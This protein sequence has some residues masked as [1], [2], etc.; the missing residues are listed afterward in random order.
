MWKVVESW[1]LDWWWVFFLGSQISDTHLPHVLIRTPIH[2]IGIDN[3]SSSGDDAMNQNIIEETN[4]ILAEI[5][6]DSD[7]SDLV[8]KPESFFS[9]NDT[10]CLRPKIST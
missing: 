5:W 9:V 3:L 8:N 2:T 1:R 4:C 6:S 7:P 10:F